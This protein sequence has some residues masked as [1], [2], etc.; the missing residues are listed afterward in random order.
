MTSGESWREKDI[1]GVDNG[2][3]C[4]FLLSPPLTS[5]LLDLEGS[6]CPRAFGESLGGSQ[7]IARSAEKQPGGLQE[8]PGHR[9][10]CRGVA[11]AAQAREQ[12]FFVLP[13]G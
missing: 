13:P 6:R 2:V 11:E 9:Q 1:V 3:S 7:G 10:V 4:P 5:S 8:Q 12:A